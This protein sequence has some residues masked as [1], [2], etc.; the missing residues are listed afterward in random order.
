MRIMIIIAAVVAAAPVNGAHYLCV[1]EHGES[2][3]TDRRIGECTYADGQPIDPPVVASSPPAV[4]GGKVQ[5]G[6]N[7]PARNPA[8][9]SQQQLESDLKADLKER[10]PTSPLIQKSA[11]D[12]HIAA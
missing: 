11:F 9:V 3:L 10:H 4:S 8:C 6:R 7:P 12:A 5:E 2:V 1:G